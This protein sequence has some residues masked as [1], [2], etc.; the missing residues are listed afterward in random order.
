[1]AAPVDVDINVHPTLFS[2][3][4]F[5][6]NASDRAATSPGP[7]ASS[8]A[9]GSARCAAAATHASLAATATV[10]SRARVGPP[11]TRAG[12]P[13]PGP[14]E[15]PPAARGAHEREHRGHRQ[16]RERRARGTN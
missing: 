4:V 16:R 15:T 8:G 10:R 13:G 1:M 11:P 12:T 2:A 14:P 7:I 3:G 5:G 6:W 9:H